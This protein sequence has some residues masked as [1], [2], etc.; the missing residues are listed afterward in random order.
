MA[1]QMTNL[2]KPAALLGKQGGKSQSPA[3]I[4]AARENGKRGGQKPSCLCG[5][6]TKCKNREYQRRWR[7]KKR[8][9]TNL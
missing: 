7:E 5:T 9:K 8:L 2:S 6:C 3:K 1:S 4:A